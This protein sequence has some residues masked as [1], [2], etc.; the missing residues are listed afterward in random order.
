MKLIELR[1]HERD[2]KKTSIGVVK[3]GGRFLDRMLVI[4]GVRRCFLLKV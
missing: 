2:R 3:F 4:S 1:V